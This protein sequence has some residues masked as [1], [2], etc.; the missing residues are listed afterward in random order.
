MQI[1][2]K[3]KTFLLLLL[4]FLGR[5]FGYGPEQIINVKTQHYAIHENFKNFTTLLHYSCWRSFRS[6]QQPVGETGRIGVKQAKKC[7][8]KG[9][10]IA[11]TWIVESGW[12]LAH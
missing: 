10:S 6:A 2:I 8:R 1:Y 7:E 11:D 3:I 12:E 4:A 5:K 9:V